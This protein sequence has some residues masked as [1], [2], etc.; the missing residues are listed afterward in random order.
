VLNIFVGV[1]VDNYN[2]AATAIPDTIKVPR[3]RRVEPEWPR[4]QSPMRII[5]LDVVTATAFDLFIAVC[6]TLNVLM[7][8]VESYQQSD[9]QKQVLTISN[10]LFTYIFTIEAIMKLFAFRPVRYFWDHWNKF[11][12]TIVVFSIIGQATD[13]AGTSSALAFDPTILRV[14][15]VFRIF[16]IL[17]AF[18]IF[19]A[20]KG[21]QTIVDSLRKSL[22][23][24]A[25]LAGVL[26]LLFFIYGIGAVELFGSLCLTSTGDVD[27]E[28]NRCSIISEDDKLDRHASFENLGLALLTLF[29]ICTNDN[30]AEVMR[31][32]AASPE[33]SKQRTMENIVR[34]LD[35]HNL[36]ELRHVLGG[37][38]T[39][40]EFDQLHELGKLSCDGD[41][42]AS[43]CGSPVSP[44]FF[45]SFVC[46]ATFVLLNLV[47]AVLMDQ[48]GEAE[49]EASSDE[50]V[51]EWLT[52]ST[53]QRIYWKWKSNA[54]KKREL[55]GGRRR[56]RPRRTQNLLG[57]AVRSSSS[58]S[59]KN[60]PSASP[61]GLSPGTAGS[62]LSRFKRNSIDSS[63]GGLMR[64]ASSPMRSAARARS[65]SVAGI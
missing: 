36:V 7:M 61:G 31:A 41:A 37:C 26:L 19:K 51:S 47:I 18:R 62:V 52:M 57:S 5:I 17:R 53:F 63:E 12:Y 3:R 2:T 33:E 15:R 56:R 16:R 21:L 22:P 39:G 64:A 50:K 34:L 58:G 10:F 59:F 4:P 27:T 11:D 65:A 8:A 55:L 42:C 24:V 14:L 20:A 28:P 40:D 44:L 48:L 23:A 38:V 1:F 29:R 54:L 9:W 6:I 32:C 43:T 60:S 13:L 46:L 45:S 49:R 30:W 35:D 25:N